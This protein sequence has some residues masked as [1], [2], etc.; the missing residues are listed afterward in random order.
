MKRRQTS[1]QL[2][3]RDVPERTKEIFR[4]RAAAEQ[5]SLNTV[6]VEALNEIAGG[7]RRYHDLDD[8]AGRWVEDP[9]FD[10]TIRAQHRIDKSLWK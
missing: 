9:A 7:D 8:L 1:V 4:R 10:A 5:K 2:T 6:V 3:I